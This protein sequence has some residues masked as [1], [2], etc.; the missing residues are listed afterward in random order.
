MQVDWFTVGAQIVNFL[1]LVYLLKRFLYAPIVNAM[2]RR[3]KR[4]TDRLREA[5]ERQEAA[6]ERESEFQRKEDELE[7][8]RQELLAEAREEAEH[9]RKELLD[10]VRGEIEEVRRR[11]RK[12]IDREK[13]SFVR[14][15]R[16]QAASWITVASRRAFREL[17]DV[18]L[19]ERVV[20]AFQERLRKLPS[21][22]RERLAEAIRSAE[23]PVRVVTTFELSETQRESLRETLK[24]E[25]GEEVDLRFAESADLV[26]GIELRTPGTALAWSL[27]AFAGELEES[28]QETLEQAVRRT[29]E[30]EDERREE[31]TEAEEE[32][33]EEEES[34]P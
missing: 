1:V 19:E 21:E 14:E 7:E 24:E 22:E 27:D 15:L 34:S 32:P 28:L 10:E 25:T 17:V 11:W 13:E 20:V 4:V 8:Q 26:C 3:E 6:E 29:T 2:D 33:R 16:G 18:D 31:R 9:R 12:E 5:Q 30:G 23:E